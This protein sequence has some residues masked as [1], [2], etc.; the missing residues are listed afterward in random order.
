NRSQW[1][2]PI[3]LFLATLP[4]DALSAFLTLCERVVYQSYAQWSRILDT[5]P[6]QDQETAG[7]L[8]WVSVTFIYLVP[9]V[10]VAIRLLSAP[11]AEEAIWKGGTPAEVQALKTDQSV[12]KSSMERKTG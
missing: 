3:Y 6:L 10:G 9:A 8:M 12:M 5:S 2:V 11:T 4:C 1:L 7:A